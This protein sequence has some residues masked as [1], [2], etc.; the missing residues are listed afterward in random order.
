MV[1]E[2]RKELSMRLLKGKIKVKL[3]FIYDLIG[4][5]INICFIK[6]DCSV[7]SRKDCAKNLPILDNSL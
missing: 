4:E 7:K 6:I 1:S 5:K 2:K 3:T